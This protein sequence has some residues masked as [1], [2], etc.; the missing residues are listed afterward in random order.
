MVMGHGEG[1]GLLPGH[2]PF[3]KLYHRLLPGQ[4][5]DRLNF[6]TDGANA[7]FV[8]MSSRIRIVIHIAVATGTGVGG[9]ALL[10][11]GGSGD[12]GI[13]G[14]SVGK[15]FRIIGKQ[16]CFYAIRNQLHSGCRGMNLV[17][18]IAGIV[19]PGNGTVLSQIYQRNIIIF[20]RCTDLGIVLLP[21]G[22][23]HRIQILRKQCHGKNLCI[24]ICITH[25]VQ[26]N[27]ISLAKGCGRCIGSVVAD[28]AAIIH[29]TAAHFASVK[30]I[31]IDAQIYE[32]H[33]RTNRCVPR[34]VFQSIIVEIHTSLQ[35]SS[36][37]HTTIAG[38][39]AKDLRASPGIVYQQL[40]TAAVSKVHPP[41]I[42]DTFKQAITA[43]LGISGSPIIPGTV[44]A[45]RC[46]HRSI[47]RVTVEGGNA[48]TQNGNIFPVQNRQEIY[49]AADRAGIIMI[50]MTGRRNFF[51]LGQRSVA[52][53]ADFSCGISRFCT[54]GFLCRNKLGTVNSKILTDLT[55]SQPVIV[56][57]NPPG[58]TDSIHPVRNSDVP[59]ICISVVN[60]ACRQ[61]CYYSISQQI[62]HTNAIN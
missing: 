34:V 24:R 29:R 17:D 28:Q 47:V 31:V 39:T 25:L 16:F 8:A 11:A 48:V 5:R 55:Q 61:A 12:R 18:H 15:I 51:S 49:S 9:K 4:S 54:G 26:H 59:V 14:V 22:F 23:V 41:G 3:P 37:N 46:I 27:A 10:G 21:G 40:H 53:L 58:N 62:G 32:N 6:A 52:D 56:T 45:D 19:L 13:I 20:C 35:I 33:I 2:H 43:R 1:D 57:G 42:I 38:L 36:G 7:V 44:S 30:I 50:D 60:L